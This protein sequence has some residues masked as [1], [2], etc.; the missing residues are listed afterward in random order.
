MTI[1]PGKKDYPSIGIKPVGAP[2]NLA[3]FGHV[4]A[5]IVN[6]GQ[7]PISVALRVDD[8]GDW[9]TIRRIRRASISSPVHPAQF[10]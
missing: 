8:A 4:E 5:Q 2:W 7:K 6:P 9:S 1:E 10:P 3:G